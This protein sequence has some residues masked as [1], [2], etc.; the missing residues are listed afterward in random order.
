MSKSWYKLAAVRATKE[1]RRVRARNVNGALEQA[2]E[3]M[4]NGIKS[5][6]SFGSGGMVVAQRTCLVLI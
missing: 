4:A 2:E 1:L 6:V 3:V 5:V